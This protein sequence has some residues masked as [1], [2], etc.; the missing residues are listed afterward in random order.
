MWIEK[1]TLGWM[2]NAH[3]IEKDKRR[4][5]RA[6]SLD[7]SP[8]KSLQPGN[9]VA[10]KVAMFVGNLSGGNEKNEEKG[11]REE[12]KEGKERREEGKGEKARWEIDGK[13]SLRLR[14]G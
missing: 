14:E 3:V 6:S 1:D 11:K 9:L 8:G 4:L 13:L 10:R 7:G 5:K 2:R 12:R